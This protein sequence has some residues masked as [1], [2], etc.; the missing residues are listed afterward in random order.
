MFP[1][2]CYVTMFLL[3]TI[4][5]EW[6]VYSV[7][8]RKNFIYLFFVS[9]VI[10]ALTLPLATY[11]YYYLYTN[12]F[13]IEMFVTLSESVLLVVLL[14]VRFP[15]SVLLSLSA[16]MVSGLLGFFFMIFR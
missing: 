3:I 1:I 13:V 5:I 14:H 2:I 4:F 10:N 6:M 16:N 9:M 12:F 15:R 8:I 11:T 7:F